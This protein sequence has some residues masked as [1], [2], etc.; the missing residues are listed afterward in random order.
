M[1]I[2]EPPRHGGMLCQQNAT[3]LGAPKARHTDFGPCLEIMCPNTALG[4]MEGRPFEVALV[5]GGQGHTP[6]GG[7]TTP[8]T[9]EQE[10][11]P[12]VGDKLAG[13]HR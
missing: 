9:Q 12:V 1:G 10:M 13:E 2:R 5:E 7:G 4:S 11:S 3:L 6:P 8:G